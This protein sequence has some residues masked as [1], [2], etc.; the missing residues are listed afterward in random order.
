L[1]LE[2]GKGLFNEKLDLDLSE[3]ESTYQIKYYKNSNER[4]E[5]LN[6]SLNMEKELL[7]NNAFYDPIPEETFLFLD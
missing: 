6:F 7:I 5:S 1:I 3:E 2:F 4:K